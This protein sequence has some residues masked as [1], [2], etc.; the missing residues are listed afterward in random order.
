MNW[1]ITPE[2]CPHNV[3]MQRVLLMAAVVILAALILK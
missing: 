3:C 2:K 1:K